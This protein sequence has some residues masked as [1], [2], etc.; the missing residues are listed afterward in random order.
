MPAIP[1]F[2]MNVQLPDGTFTGGPSDFTKHPEYLGLTSVSLA[3]KRV[4][5][6]A[7]NDGFWSFW[8]EKAGAS[9][10]LATDVEN[11]SRYDWGFDG[12][13][14]SS[15][16]WGQQNKDEGFWYLHRLFQS[17]VRREPVSVYELSPEQHGAFDLVFM[18]GLLY[19]L[20]HPLLALDRVRRVCSGVLILETHVICSASIIPM[21]FFYMDDVF[22]APTNWTGPTEAAIVHWLFSAGFTHIYTGRGRERGPHDRQIFI[23]CVNDGW[24]SVFAS[25]SNFNFCDRSYFERSRQALSRSL[26]V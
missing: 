21:S 24:H 8:A 26:G 11:Y 5:D 9:D 15:S 25:L 19:H 10:V 6:I 22:C 3:G 23:A 7:A 2:H 1:D 4:L 16:D 18:F 14:E 12:P 13:A 17:K 20:R